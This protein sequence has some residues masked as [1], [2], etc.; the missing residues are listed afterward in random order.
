MTETA[1]SEAMGKGGMA[2]L[3]GGACDTGRR[4]QAG[5]TAAGTLGVLPAPA[6]PTTTFCQAGLLIQWAPVGL[7]AATRSARHVGPPATRSPL[8]VF[9]TLPLLHGREP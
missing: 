3:Q 6:W 1:E 5:G 7:L 9:V 4:E 8:P 2:D